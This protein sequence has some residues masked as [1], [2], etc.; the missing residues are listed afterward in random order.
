MLIGQV[1]VEIPPGDVRFPTTPP[2][3]QRANVTN[4]LNTFA[5]KIKTNI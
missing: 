3:V 5:G 2:V 1:S 4:N